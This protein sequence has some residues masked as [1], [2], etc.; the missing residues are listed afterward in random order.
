MQSPW[1]EVRKEMV[2]VKG[3]APE[4]ADRIHDF[5]VLKGEPNTLLKKVFDEKLCDGNETAM[6]ALKELQ[7]L[8]EYLE[9][10]GCLDKVSIYS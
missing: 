4:A 10:Y 5:V 6:K 8:F 7:V 1:E 9:C 2:E 3:L